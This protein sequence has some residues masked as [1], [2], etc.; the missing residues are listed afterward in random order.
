M[1]QVSL[2]HTT[3]VLIMVSLILAACQDNSS[4]DSS[5]DDPAPP[6]VE[7]GQDL[8]SEEDQA[9]SAG[10]SDPAEAEATETAEAESNPE[11]PPIETTPE[12]EKEAIICMSAPPSSFYPYGD[13]SISSIAI[14][15]ALYE[16]LLTTTGYEHQAAGLEA[17]PNLANGDARIENVLVNEGS[18]VVDHRGNILTLHNDVMIINSAGEAVTYEGTPIEMKQMIVDFTLKPL[19]WSDGTPV[20]AEDSVYSYSLAADDELAFRNSAF[21]QTA[22]YEATGDLSLRWVGLPGYLDPTYFDNAWLPLPAH[23]DQAILKASADIEQESDQ[24]RLSSGPFMLEEVREDGSVVLAKNPHY[25]RSEEGLPRIDQ[26]VIRFG[27]LE[28]FLAENGEEAC[29]LISND[30]LSLT[31]MPLL[32]SAVDMGDWNLQ[33]VPGMA[34]EYI[35]FGV[36]PALEYADRRPDWFEDAQVRQA[37]TMCVDRESMA[38]ELTGGLG[39]VIHSYVPIDHPLYPED[40]QVWPYDPDAANQLLDELGYADFAE[41]GRRQDLSTGVPM[42]ITLGTNSESLIRLGIQEQVQANLSDCGIPVDTYDQSA[43]NWYAAGPQGI[44]FGRRFDL[45]SLA[46]ISRIV[47]DCGLFLSDNVTGPEEFGFGG[48]LNVNVTGWNNEAY[49]AAC[50][51]AAT[52]LPGGEGYDDF[53]REALRIFSEELPAMPLLSNSKL[54]VV[55]DGLL[56]VQLDSSQ[57]SILW[58]IYEWDIE[59]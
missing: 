52:V 26:V 23:Q 41:D 53:Q 20:T 30:V 18:R 17:L 16:P 13:Q 5:Q 34:F 44:L 2:N 36:N 59:Q 55:R 10:S 12:P 1:R 14:R 43:G 9:N 56:N 22:R 42:T 37:I 6:V 39:E 50:R 28:E 48:W 38:Q 57:P 24:L 8:S 7:N 46:W 3:S 58:N 47:P 54:A 19:V 15:Q 40:G 49:D 32:E 11:Q 27:G 51:S 35:A 31:D 25:Y 21:A 33:T 4:N 45:A 29:D